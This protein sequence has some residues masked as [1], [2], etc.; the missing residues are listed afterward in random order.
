MSKKR[1]LITGITGQDGSYLAEFLLLQGYEVHG[2]I[3]RSSTLTRW[4]IDH[5]SDRF[6]ENKDYFLHYGDLHDESSLISVL[7]KTQPDEIY[8]LAAQ[9]HVRISFDTPVGTSDVVALGTIRLLDAVRVI[10]PKAKFYQA[11]SSEMFGSSNPPQ[12]ELSPFRPRS[13]Y[14]VSKL[15]SH[16]I[17]ENYREGYSLFAVSGILFNHESPRRGENFVTQK[18]AA[19]AIEISENRTKRLKL[20][21]LDSTRDWGYAP[22]YVI[23]MWKMLQKEDPRD[24]V[25]GTGHT[26][27]VKQFAQWCFEEV[28]LDWTNHVDIEPTLFRPTEVDALLADPNLAL[29][30]LDWKPNL[31]GKELAIKLVKAEEVRRSTKKMMVDSWINFE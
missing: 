18:I 12:S 24:Y 2:L 11:S 4:R 7:Q 8:N 15:F 30:N 26:Y 25:I 16:W 5:L 3:R 28:G 20:G 23:A 6:E 31:M 10:S 14:A 13:P 1:A 21:N 9:S 27:S 29:L 17:T 19:A 22:E